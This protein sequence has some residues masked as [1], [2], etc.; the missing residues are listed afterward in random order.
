MKI[1][2]GKRNTSAGRSSFHAVGIA[3]MPAPFEKAL[4]AMPNNRIYSMD[5]RWQKLDYKSQYLLFYRTV[6]SFNYELL[7]L[8]FSV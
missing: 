3:T 7:S 6:S 4:K 5:P 8:Y 1:E 2:R